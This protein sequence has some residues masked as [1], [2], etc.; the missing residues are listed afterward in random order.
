LTVEER[1]ASARKSLKQLAK[2]RQR[3]PFSVSGRHELLRE[4]FAEA[5]GS[6]ARGEVLSQERKTQLMSMHARIYN[7]LPPEEQA[8]L[9]RRARQFALGREQALAGDIEGWQSQLALE[10]HRK[11]EENESQGMMMSMHNSRL[12]VGGEREIA[13]YV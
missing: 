10:R 13:R 8:G 4:M 12:T 11:Q 1:S 2:A 5:S 9:E 3:R 7:E 6:L